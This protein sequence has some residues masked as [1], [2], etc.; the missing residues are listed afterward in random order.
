MKVKLL[1]FSLLYLIFGVK[2]Q[3]I[4]NVQFKMVSNVMQI[5]YDI[6]NGK[7]DRLYDLAIKIEFIDSRDSLVKKT[8]TPD[9]ITGDFLKIKNGRNNL[10]KWDVL[11][12]E[13]KLEGDIIVI[14]S[15][16]HTHV[17]QD[18]YFTRL[19]VKEKW[20]P[21]AALLSLALP[22]LGYALVGD[23]EKARKKGI[24]IFGIY[25]LSAYGAYSF[26]ES[27]KQNYSLYQSSVLQSEMDEYYNQANSDLRLAKSFV[28]IA[29]TV[30]MIEVVY[31]L[32]KGIK[33]RSE[34]PKYGF[35]KYLK[36][37]LEYHTGILNIGLKKTF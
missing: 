23:S 22:G 3:E 20:G 28:G 24:M 36:L 31:V 14:V 32:Y 25:A 8:I 27:S 13:E 15:I 2:A 35:N 19:K 5:S 11:A 17:D 29:G 16:K 12:E 30:L 37:N 33:N 6:E 34:N 7:K 18:N 10:I 26:N 1:I 21:E 9:K 4:T